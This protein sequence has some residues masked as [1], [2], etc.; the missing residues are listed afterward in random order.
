MA[1]D[2]PVIERKLVEVDR[3]NAE[4]RAVAEAMDLWANGPGHSG[5]PFAIDP[6]QRMYEQAV[7]PAQ[8]ALADGEDRP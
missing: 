4:H 1:D 8:Q 2:T 3:G 7:L 6:W 5:N